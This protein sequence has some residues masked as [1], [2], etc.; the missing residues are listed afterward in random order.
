MAITKKNSIL[1]VAVLKEL[2]TANIK[3]K[4]ILI[5]HKSVIGL[6]DQQNV[7]LR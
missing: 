2:T 1:T 5:K 3:T 4:K 7:C 6:H